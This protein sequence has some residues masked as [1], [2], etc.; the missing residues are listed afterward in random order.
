MVALRTP[1]SGVPVNVPDGL[2]ERYTAAG[3]VP[4]EQPKKSTTRAKRAPSK[5]ADEP[6]GEE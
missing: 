3:Y 1:Y 6:A 2:V 4:V 5:P